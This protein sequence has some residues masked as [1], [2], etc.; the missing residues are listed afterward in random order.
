MTDLIPKKFEFF[1]KDI[2]G[3]MDEIE[4][5]D[6]NIVHV[7]LTS[8][9]NFQTWTKTVKNTPVDEADW[10]F[11]T[12][13]CEPL[14]LQHWHDIY[15]IAQSR[16][17]QADNN[18][19]DLVVSRGFKWRIYFE[20]DTQIYSSMGIYAYPSENNPNELIYNSDG[21]F[22]DLCEALEEV[23]H[24]RFCHIDRIDRDCFFKYQPNILL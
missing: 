14:K 7:R 16:Q 8:D 3:W 23:L 17:Q 18:D 4:Y 19:S 5:V 12:A 13:L 9:E 22:G 10:Q 1:A 20:I 11:F 21:L 2:D 24:Y 6:G 15:D